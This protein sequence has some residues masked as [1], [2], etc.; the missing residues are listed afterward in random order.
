MLGGMLTVSHRTATAVLASLAPSLELPPI[1]AYMART[2]G[3]PR[4]RDARAQH[5]FVVRRASIAGDA[6]LLRTLECTDK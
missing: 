4:H 6:R 1:R 3:R 5:R 2:L